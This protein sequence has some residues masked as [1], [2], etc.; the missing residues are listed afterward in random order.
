VGISY[1]DDR[2][3]AVSLSNFKTVTLRSYLAGSAN[4]RGVV[5]VVV[6]WIFIFL[7][8]VALD[9][10]ASVREEAAAAH[11]Y[12]E[13]AEGYYVALAG[14]QDG[15]YQIFQRSSQSRP[16]AFVQATERID[17]TWSE[18]NLGEARFRVRFIDEG[19]KVN[20]NRADEEM[21]RRVFINLG[22]EEPRRTI[23]VD[24][25]LDWRDEDDF[26]RTNGAENDYY[27]SLTQLYTARNGPFETV[28][29]LLWVRGM[30]PQLFYGVEE[31]GLRTPGLRTIFTVDTS[32]NRVNV[33][34]ASAEV[35]HAL[36]G[37]G[38]GKS[39]QFVEERKK[40]S[41]KTMAD[42]LRLLGLSAGDAG[43]R[44]FVFV[45][46]SVITVEA[47]GRRAGS[48]VERRIKGV[49]RLV[50]ANRSYEI[51]RWSDRYSGEPDRDEE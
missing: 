12:A 8:V 31:E 11:R 32:T 29:D 15:L 40:L 26:H 46:A 1:H 48:T 39:R 47:A 35:I 9:F 24:S 43:L 22:V 30:T 14:F 2:F 5:L 49:I 42:L 37:I 33:R 34:S 18:G 38:L 20:L 41:D 17:G 3:G 25:I 13:E 6:L 27:L 10:S 50:G 21:L 45:P 19:G 28:E 4:E 36:L 44:Y 16:G 23:L 7:F 51:L